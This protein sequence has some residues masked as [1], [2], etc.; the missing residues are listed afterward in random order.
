MTDQ[1]DKR[2]LK[3]GRR[4]E[5]EARE[6]DRTL[7]EK[8]VS[9]T[10]V[11]LWFVLI[12]LFVTM[13]GAAVALKSTHDQVD[14][15]NAAAATSRKTAAVS[16]RTADQSKRTADRLAAVV[17]EIQ[18]QRRTNIRGNC[19]D[20]NDRHDRTL[21]RLQRLARR[22]HVPRARLAP[23]IGLIDALAPKQSCNALVR[24][25]TS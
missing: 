2:H 10:N 3:P 13:A 24:R 4:D 11:L 1:P 21:R 17:R 5:D 6:Q 14:R 23:T 16:K 7:V 9:R 8:T 19:K 25:Q 12:A 22:Q 20:Q 18:Q 15:L